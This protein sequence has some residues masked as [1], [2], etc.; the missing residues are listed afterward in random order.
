MSSKISKEQLLDYVRRSELVNASD[1][2]DFVADLK[3]QSEQPANAE[4]LSKLLIEAKLINAWHAE[5]MLRGKYKGFTL[6]K[7]RLLG[8]LGTGGM[9]SVFLAEHPVMKRLVAIKVLPKKY[10]EDTN[11]L[12]RFKREARAVAALDHT[13]IVRAYDI[14]QDGNRHYIVMEYVDGRDLQRL[15]KD[16]GPLDPVDAADYIAQAA[17][18]LQHAHDEGLIHRDVKPANCLLDTH[19]VLKLLDMGLAKFSEEERSLS[20]IYDDTVVGTADFLAPEQAI[21]SQKVDSRADVYGLGCTFYFLL[22]GHPPFPEGTIAERLLK[23]Q[24]QEPESILHIRPDISP[25]LVDIV[26]RMMIK[27]PEERIQSTDIVAEELEQW[28][29]AR[30]TRR[31]RTT[32]PSRDA[33]DSSVVGGRFG[34]QTPPPLPPKTGSP[35][36]ETVS[37]SGSDTMKVG[38]DSSLNDDLTLAPIDD[39]VLSGDSSRGSSLKLSAQV[40]E[41]ADAE[42]ETSLEGLHLE[43]Y[44]S[45]PLDDLLADDSFKGSTALPRATFQSKPETG[46]PIGLILGAVAAVLVIGT[47]ALIVVMM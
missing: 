37:S 28:K 41:A 18:G 24:T 26:R 27:V 6:G 5:N 23:H 9:S 13:N 35:S 33:G 39:E 32:T 2:R 25:A 11:Y 4:E 14:D 1:L 19:G 46:A 15:V 47:I 17:R 40:D 43:A 20:V 38:T 45:G 7:Y 16:I 42:V 3:S 34:R 44:E 12:E 21:N 22:V 31:G 30:T 8:H 10:V 29:E 36:A